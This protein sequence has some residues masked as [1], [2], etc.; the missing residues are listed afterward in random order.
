MG[1][2]GAKTGWKSWMNTLNKQLGR[3]VLLCN[4]LAL[5]W[6]YACC[7]VTWIPC[8]VHP[9]LSLI[10]FTFPAA[11]VACM[12]FV[13]VWLVLNVKRLWIPLVGI[14]L[15]WS[16]VMDYCPIRLSSGEE[17]PEGLKVVTWNSKYMGGAE[18]YDAFKDYMKN[19][20]ADII[21]LQETECGK[22]GWEDF[23]KDMK[24]QG[25]EYSQQ[26]L[27]LLT[28][29][30]ILD[31]DTLKYDT[32]SNGVRWF[33]IAKE[34]DTILVLNCHLESNH[35][36]AEVKEE[37]RQ[38]I[39]NPEYAKAKESGHSMLPLMIKSAYYRGSQARAMRD[40]IKEHQGEHIIVCGD[41]NDTP[42]SYAFQTL[43]RQL[44]SNYRESG[45]GVGV[46]YNERGF[47]VRIDH[48]FHSDDAE[49]SN[50]FI[51]QSIGIS[52]H[53]PVISWVNFNK[54]QH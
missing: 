16:Y 53:Y 9:R 47:W 11:L 41:F 28:R 30:H 43:S 21:C 3:L 54:N 22:A 51:D 35:M 2:N 31:T 14:L 8:D 48:I 24:D 6:L 50:T 10:T 40:F 5:L 18:N 25:Y 27:E 12:L 38:V 49:S 39:D 19:L 32:R 23:L 45:R 4:I 52:D 29:Y 34:N 46:S 37:Y 13:P 42:I 36:P 26:K 7:L 44:V 17:V 20:N 33:R 15:C 1:K